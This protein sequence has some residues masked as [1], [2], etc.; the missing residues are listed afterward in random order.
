MNISPINAKSYLL[1]LGEKENTGVNHSN[2]HQ[3]T[4]GG[5]EGGMDGWMDGGWI[6]NTFPL[7]STSSTVVKQCFY[8]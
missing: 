6:G 1:K 7:G 8:F 4:M 2:T 5:R 3:H